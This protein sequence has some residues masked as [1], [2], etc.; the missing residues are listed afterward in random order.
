MAKQVS[1]QSE[2][3]RLIADGI[4]AGMSKK[5]ATAH[6]DDILSTPDVVRIGQDGKRVIVSDGQQL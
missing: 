1:K 5:S 4:A 3:Q 2:R 6:A